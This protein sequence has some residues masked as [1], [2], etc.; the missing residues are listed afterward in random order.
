VLLRIFASGHM[1]DIVDTYGF[2]EN[3]I[4]QYIIYLIKFISTLYNIDFIQFL[5]DLNEITKKRR[6]FAQTRVGN[7]FVSKYIYSLK[8]LVKKKKYIYIIK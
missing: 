6:L 4:S 2:D 8:I 3:N 1:V 7:L 5:Q